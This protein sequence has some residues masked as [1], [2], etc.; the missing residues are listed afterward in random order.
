MCYSV[1]PSLLQAMINLIGTYTRPIFARYLSDTP[2]W[3][4]LLIEFGACDIIFSSPQLLIA[5]S[6]GWLTHK[7]GLTVRF[8]RRQTEMP[9]PAAGLKLLNENLQINRAPL[10]CQHST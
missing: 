6:G 1:T 4:G 8:E 2:E 10:E 9:A 7:H 5:L 3:L